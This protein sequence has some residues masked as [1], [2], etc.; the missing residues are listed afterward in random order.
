MNRI[1]ALARITFLN[2]LRRN[3][4]W[5]LALFA[6]LFEVAGS[7]FMDFFGRDLGRVISDFQFSIMWVSG[8]LFI[9]FYAIQAIAWDDDHRAIDSILARPISRTEYVLGTILGLSILL[10]C[11]EA[12]LGI[13]AFVQILWVKP[14]IE[15]IYFPIFSMPH[16]WM[17]WLGLQFILLGLLSV[18]MLISSAIR[19]AFPV[20]LMTLAY[21]LICSGLPVVRESLKQKANG[22]SQ[23]LEQ[24]LQVLNMIF[25]DYATLDFKD[26]VVSQESIASLIGM[27]VWMPLTLIGLYIVVVIFL[28]CL[29]YQRRDIL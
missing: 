17:T 3:A 14:M 27:P 25:P 24:L 5:G 16:Y 6:L 20:M 13:T 21:A 1:F 8:M 2:G 9:L 26:S 29:I 7:L 15:E 22:A 10:F 19:G 23:G 12:L 28:T 11:F 4:V 18:A